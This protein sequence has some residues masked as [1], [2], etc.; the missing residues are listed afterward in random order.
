MSASPKILVI[1]LSSLGDILHAL[2]AFAGLRASFPK[3]KIDWLVAPKCKF[4][5][6]AVPG[7]DSIHCLDTDALR[8]LSGS[9]PAWR[10]F[11]STLHEL[12]AGRY[13]YAIDFQ[14]LIKTALLSYLSGSKKRLGFSKDLVRE[15]PAHWFYH[16]TLRRP[17]EQLHILALNQKLA[18]LAGGKS[19]PAFC[20]FLVSE[21]DRSVVDALLKQKQLRDFVVVNPGGGWATKRWAP[22]RYG[23]LA[24]RIQAELGLP[25][26]VTT[27]PGEEMLF[28][29][30]MKHSGSPFPVHLPVSFLQLVPLLKKARL[31]TG[32]DTGPFH[33]ACATGTPVVG[34]FGPTSPVRNGPWRDKDEVVIRMLPCSACYKRECPTRNECMDISVDEVLA[35][36]MR[37][38]RNQGD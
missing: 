14:G 11:W 19:E 6:S 20:E 4:L 38:L 18:Q 1:R 27:G 10:R 34:I 33:L 5:L 2:P 13:D 7:I 31:F 9:R 15:P 8:H 12:R 21:N 25:V 17:T 3:G 23:L 29:E 36:V 22:E 35:A 16:Q 30:I 28:H 37:R 32:G 26:A 24:K